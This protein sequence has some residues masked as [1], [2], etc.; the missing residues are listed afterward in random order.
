M[1]NGNSC[2]VELKKEKLHENYNTKSALYAN[3][4]LEEKFFA[5]GLGCISL[6]VSLTQVCHGV[7]GRVAAGAFSPQ[8]FDGRERDNEE[9]D[10]RH[11]ETDQ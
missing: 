4:F 1:I 10:Q 9:D 5:V 2:E 8:Q 3:G 11:G 7:H 6:G